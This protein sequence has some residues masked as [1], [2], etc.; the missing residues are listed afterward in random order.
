MMKTRT[1][2]SMRQAQRDV[3]VPKS[4]IQHSRN[5]SIEF[6]SSISSI[7]RKGDQH[8]AMARRQQQWGVNSQGGDRERDREGDRESLRS[9]DLAIHSFNPVYDLVIDDDTTSLATP[10]RSRTQANPRRRRSIADR[11]SI[12]ASNPWNSWATQGCR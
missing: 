2:C 7:S 1:C 11:L 3:K 9:P 6:R 8:F 5:K 12:S 10:M 4:Q